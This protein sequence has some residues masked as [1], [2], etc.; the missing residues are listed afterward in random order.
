MSSWDEA[1]HK[2]RLKDN[3]RFTA[4]AEDKPLPPR[5]KRKPAPSPPKDKP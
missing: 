2:A 5:S 1:M 3:P 4:I